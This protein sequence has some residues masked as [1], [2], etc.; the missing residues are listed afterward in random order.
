MGN[1]REIYMNPQEVLI[2]SPTPNLNV[3]I[4]TI[5]VREGKIHC[6]LTL[7]IHYIGPT[8]KTKQKEEL[9]AKMMDYCWWGK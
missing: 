6:V 5:A 8:V 1:L 9:L 7:F 2:T 3:A 4:L